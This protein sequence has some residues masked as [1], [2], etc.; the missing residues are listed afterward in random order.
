MEILNFSAKKVRHHEKINLKKQ[1][2]YEFCKRA[3]DIVC[4]LLG[5]I[6]LSWIFIIVSVIIMIEDGENPIFKQER[7]GKNDKCFY[8]HKFRTMVPD[9]EKILERLQSANEADG[10]I[11][12]IA[13]DPRITKVGKF[14][15]RSSI[16]ELPQLFDILVGNMS[17]VGPRPPLPNEVEKYNEYQRQRLMVKP[18]LT[19]YWQCSGR[20]KLSFDEWMDMDIK[21]IK[22]RSIHTDILILL[23]TIPA[24]ICGDGAY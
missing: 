18:G 16:D 22:E 23:K 1:P 7:V 9:A 6:C 24:V 19:C 10:P 14:L 20:S 11:F 3:F 21:Y 17:F 8:M 12:K 5:L 13:N 15:R 2:I 4:S